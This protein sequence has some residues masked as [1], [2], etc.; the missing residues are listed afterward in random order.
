MAAL[1]DPQP[2]R[3]D[4]T[5]AEKITPE[6]L[7]LRWAQPAQQVARVV[8]LGRAWTTFR[9]RRLGVL[10]A[11]LD[12]GEATRDDSPP[13]TLHGARVSAGEGSLLLGRVQPESRSP[14]SADEWLRGVRPEDG[15]RLGTD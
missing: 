12:V 2:Q 15:E 3:G 9:G 14:M 8:R 6:D 4:V 1:P 5:V 11:T 13:G 10:D 7:H